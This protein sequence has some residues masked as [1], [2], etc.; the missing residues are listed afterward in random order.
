MTGDEVLEKCWK[1][2]YK[3]DSRP[4][5]IGD[6][7]YS[8]IMTTTTH[9]TYTGDLTTPTISAEGNWSTNPDRVVFLVIKTQVQR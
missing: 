3:N 2:K 1:A 5:L 8:P 7:A 9:S 4:W 6:P